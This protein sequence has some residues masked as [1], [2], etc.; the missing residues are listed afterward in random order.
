M[1][2][3]EVNDLARGLAQIVE[4]YFSNPENE[5]KF[6]RWQEERNTTESH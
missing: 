4:G 3:Q 5:E 2:E 6:Q 1:S